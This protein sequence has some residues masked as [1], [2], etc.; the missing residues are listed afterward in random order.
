MQPARET[1]PRQDASDRQSAGDVR[2]GPGGDDDGRR[3]PL[4]QSVLIMMALAVASI[5]ALAITMSAIA[6][7]SRQ[8]VDPAGSVIP[9]QPL[10]TTPT[11]NPPDASSAASAPPRQPSRAPAYTPTAT[12]PSS[13][14]PGPPPPTP[15]VGP[16]P[17]SRDSRAP[18]TTTHATVNR[19]FPLESTDFPGPYG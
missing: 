1:P 16:A 12:V 17:R 10:S 3:G 8:E 5:V 6:V 2:H 7:V 4:S 15:P 11:T 13:A 18:V 9:T 19:P 14:A